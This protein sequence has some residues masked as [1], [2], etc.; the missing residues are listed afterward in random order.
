MRRLILATALTSLTLASL[1]LGAHAADQQRAAPAFS[2][3]NVRGAIN[4][5]VDRGAAQSL[6]VRGDQRFLNDLVSEVVGGELR[7]SMRDNSSRKNLRGDEVVVVSMPALR[8]FSAEGAGEIKLNDVRGERFDVN[9]RGAGSLRMTGEVKTF[10]MQAEGVG[11]VDARSLLADN[12]DVT[13][14]GVGDVRVHARNR[15]DAKVQGIGSLTYYG[16]PR[17]VNKSASGLGS[18]DAGN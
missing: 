18:V 7:L 1:A 13:F 6:T 11:E 9:Y 15:L 10:Y 12:V 17:I 16:K 5:T 14:R 3:I 8:A 4:V 2:S